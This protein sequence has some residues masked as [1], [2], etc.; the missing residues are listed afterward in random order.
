MLI[1]CASHKNERSVARSATS[2]LFRFAA[3]IIASSIA[4]A[5]RLLGGQDSD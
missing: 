1:I 5:M 4:A 3:G 2:S